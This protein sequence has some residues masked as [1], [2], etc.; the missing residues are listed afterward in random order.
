MK[1]INYGVIIKKKL[2]I[3]Y[4]QLNTNSMIFINQ[5]EFIKKKKKNYLIDLLKL[6]Y[7]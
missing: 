4:F 1:I 3:L 7:N 2:I 5:N 6:N